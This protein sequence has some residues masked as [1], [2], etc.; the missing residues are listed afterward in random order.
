MILG[1]LLTLSLTGCSTL[2]VTADGET[3]LIADGPLPL[4]LTDAVA[5][6]TTPDQRAVAAQQ[7][8]SDPYGNYLDGHRGTKWAL[9]GSEGT[10]FRVDVYYWWESGDLLPPDQGNAVWGLACRTY[11]VAAPDVVTTAV[12]CPED[13]PAA[14]S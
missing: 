10:T 9:R 14:P 5:G 1:A 6:A 12:E 7:W 4:A 2:Q 8:F 11:D 3:A 13:T